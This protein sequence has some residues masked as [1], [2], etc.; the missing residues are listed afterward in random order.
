MVNRDDAMALA[1]REYISHL[2]ACRLIARYGSDPE[3]FE[4]ALQR[5]KQARSSASKLRQRKTRGERAAEREKRTA[6][7]F[8]KEETRRAAASSKTARLR[9]QRLAR[10]AAERK[11][12]ARPNPK[13]HK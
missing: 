11:A 5:L 10:E 3:K 8:A 2:Q 7:V 1:S 9:S 12:D 4:V 6:A 13:R